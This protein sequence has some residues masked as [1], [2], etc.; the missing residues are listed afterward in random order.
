MTKHA[1]MKDFM[2]I[3]IAVNNVNT[4]IG[5]RGHWLMAHHYVIYFSKDL[6]NLRNDMANF[7]KLIKKFNFFEYLAIG[8]VHDY[9]WKL[10]LALCMKFVRCLKWSSKESEDYLIFLLKTHH[11]QDIIK[12]L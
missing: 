8:Q 3:L 7:L 11:H 10:F 5:S 6:H 12:I 2:H 4:K 9:S 1:F